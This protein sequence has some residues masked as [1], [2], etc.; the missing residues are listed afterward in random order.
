MALDQSEPLARAA[1]TAIRAGDTTALGALLAANT[2]LAGTLIVDP[3][4]CGRTL[5][6]IATDWP[7]NFPQVASSIALLVKA[8]ADVNARFSGSHKETP[9][10]WAA[11]CNDIAAID[12]LLDCGA[13]TEADGGVIAHGTPL[14]DAVAFGQWA[15]AKRLVERGARANL[16][17]AAALGMHTQVAAE[18]SAQ[19]APS[20][21]AIDIAF[22][23]ACHGD[24]Q[25]T[26][27]QLLDRGA[28]L[29]K[30]GFDD[31]T[32]LGAAV[33]AQALG[34]AAWLRA[35]GAK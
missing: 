31:L 14:A 18:L 32:P 29:N 11:S 10:H 12:A 26:A 8:G 25:N 20:R 13:A 3:Q 9:L 1:T 33:R 2:S 30:L 7:G 6:H 22:W 27:E 5:L 23:Y 28:A 16:W 19:T 34:L 35:R 15:A 4:G 21:E 24:A 17:Q